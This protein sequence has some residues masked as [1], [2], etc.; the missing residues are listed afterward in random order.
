VLSNVEKK[1]SKH[2]QNVVFHM[3]NQ[4][5]KHGFS[6]FPQTVGSEPVLLLC[7]LIRIP[8]NGIHTFFILWKTFFLPSEQ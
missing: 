1:P 7:F 6:G 8:Q 2:R 5:K 4:S 3:A